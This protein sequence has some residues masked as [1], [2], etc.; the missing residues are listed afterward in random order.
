MN[1]NYRIRYSM[2]SLAHMRSPADVKTIDLQADLE[3]VPGLLP[4]GAY[5]MY[6]EDLTQRQNVHWTRLAQ[7][8]PAGIRRVGR[9]RRPN[10]PRRKFF[11]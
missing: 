1:S 2:Q 6:I 8:L 4:S 10:C 9:I 5:I 11:E 7:G 3:K